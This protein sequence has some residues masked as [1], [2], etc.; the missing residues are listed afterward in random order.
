MAITKPP[1]KVSKNGK[2]MYL[3]ASGNSYSSKDPKRM[4][5]AYTNTSGQKI[6]NFAD[7]TKLVNGTMPLKDLSIGMDNGS[8]STQDQIND[9]V[10][11]RGGKAPVIQANNI[12]N[13]GTF[14]GGTRVNDTTASTA[15]YSSIMGGTGTG[16]TGTTGTGTT[17]TTG[18]GITGTTGT[19]TTG[20]RPTDALINQISGLITKQGEQDERQ[21]ALDKQY[22]IEQLQKD[23]D[24]ISATILKTDR[25][26][27]NK[28]RDMQDKGGGLEMGLAG[29]MDT[30]SRNR[31]RELADLAI[32]EAVAIQ[33]LNSAM[34]IVDRKIKAE[35][36][37]L[38]NQITNLGN[39]YGMM[40]NDMSE[41][42]QMMAQ[43]AIQEK[44]ANKT[45]AQNA[46]TALYSALFE[47]GAA[48][49]DRLAM[50]SEGM[51]AAS[52]AIANGQDPTTAVT[53]M[54]SALNGVVSP[55][56]Q[57]LML[58]YAQL[59][60]QRKNSEWDRYVDGFGI[61]KNLIELANAGDPSAIAE[62]GFD[63]RSTEGGSTLLAY[64][65]LYATT[66]T[67][68]TGLKDAGIPFS[69]VAALAQ[70]LPQAPGMVVDGSTGVKPPNVSSEQMR[71]FAALKDL[72]DKVA[73]LAVLQ[74]GRMG[75]ITAG[76]GRM[77]FQQDDE[78]AYNSL[79]TEITDLL[80][81]ARTG[82]AITEY[83]F[84]QYSSLLPGA[85]TEPMGWGGSG[86]TKVESFQKNVRNTLDTELDANNFK[87]IGYTPIDVGGQSVTVGDVITNEAG[88]RGR[89]NANGTIT[90][91]E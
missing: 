31:N 9:Y 77:V 5:S 21:A 80:A 50:I 67:I 43:A 32:Q 88:Q 29:E 59:D 22:K 55:T 30:L 83:E 72:N 91:L 42:E 74:E 14:T 78:S 24:R 49:P 33:D 58:Q 76:I 13:T 63:P 71:R 87:M 89:V 15:L 35:F 36:E 39:L 48:T 20:G 17:G 45:Y 2:T 69:D 73:Q 81:R 3:S 46:S 54:Y 34:S 19:G 47:A 56:Q 86:A 64:A 52:D 53:E 25:A 37:P 27:E 16:T 12:G 79:R 6:Q 7:G 38:Q 85:I 40:Q 61:R 70:T 65:Q 90:I 57:N 68:P 18:T 44:Q 28:L 51:S 60:L 66:G 10:T 82:A 8:I 84:D 4:V 11:T 1:T 41:S 26:Y 62:L 23:K 75:G